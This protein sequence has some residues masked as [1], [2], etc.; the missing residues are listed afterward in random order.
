MR[1]A[2][3]IWMS[4][5]YNHKGWKVK[6]CGVGWAPAGQRTVKLVFTSCACLN[7]LDESDKPS[8]IY[9]TQVCRTD[10][11][12]PGEN[13]GKA[14]SLWNNGSF[15][16]NFQF[17]S[18]SAFFHYKSGLKVPFLWYDWNYVAH[19]EEVEDLHL[20]GGGGSRTFCHSDGLHF[21]QMT[22]N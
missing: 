7:F 2:V 15:G 17:L 5:L 16:P 13:R 1:C 3:V 9:Q 8:I 21:S 6:C 4:F 14:L 18:R 11:N 12:C 20:W 22:S 19:L 10:S